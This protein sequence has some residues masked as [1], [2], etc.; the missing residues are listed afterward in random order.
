M[1]EPPATQVGTVTGEAPPSA[2]CRAGEAT[3]TGDRLN[4]RPRSQL[5]VLGSSSVFIK[6]THRQH[7]PRGLK[8]TLSPDS[9]PTLLCDSL[10]YAPASVSPPAR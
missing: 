7:L 4:A 6:P 8:E 9:A 1:R 10:R 2:V 3:G 5:A